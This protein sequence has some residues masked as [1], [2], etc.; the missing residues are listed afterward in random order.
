MEPEYPSPY[1]QVPASCPYPEPTPFSPHDPP[2]N[3]LK[4]HPNIILPSTSWSPQWP[5]SP[6]FL[7]VILNMCFYGEGLLAP[8]PNPKLENH[9]SSAVRGCL[10]NLFTATLHIGGRSSIRNLRTRH[11]VVTGTHIHGGIALCILNLSTKMASF[12]QYPHF[13]T[14]AFFC[15]TISLPA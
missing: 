3:F 12:T 13:N 4:I 6:Q 1:P 9:P 2:P 5:L 10:F 8:R 15:L 11:V 14:L 7:W